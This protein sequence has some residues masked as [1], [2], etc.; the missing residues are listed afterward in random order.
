MSKKL[1]TTLCVLLAIGL[2]GLFYLAYTESNFYKAIQIKSLIKEH[3]EAG[4]HGQAALLAKELLINHPMQKKD[5]TV[6]L[7]KMAQEQQLQSIPAEE[8]ATVVGVLAEFQLS[9]IRF[10]KADLFTLSSQKAQEL[11][12]SSPQIAEDLL[13]A[14]VDIVPEDRYQEVHETRKILLE[15]ILAKSPGNVKYSVHLAEIYE[16]DGDANKCITILY[17]LAN[18]LGDTEGARILGRLL[19]AD[20]P[21]TAYTLLKGYVD[22]WLPRFQSADKEYTAIREN[23]WAKTIDDLNRGRG[24]DE[25][26]EAYNKA[27]EAKQFELIQNY[28]LKR[29]ENNSAYHAAYANYFK[30]SNVVSAAFDFGILLT[31]RAQQ[32][33]DQGKRKSLLTEAEQTFLAIQSASNESEEFNLALGQVY[34]WLGKYDEGKTLFNNF[35]ELRARDYQSLM[36]ISVRLRQVGLTNEAITLL[37]EAYEKASTDEERYSTAEYRT[38]F[39]RGHE[40]KR[41]WLNRSNPSNPRVIAEVQVLDGEVAALKGDYSKAIKHF[42]NAIAEYKKMEQDPVILNDTALIYSNLYDI[43]GDIEQLKTFGSLLTQAAQL[44][45]KDSIQL[46]NTASAL[47]QIG[48]TEIVSKFVDLSDIKIR[49]G[50][51]TLQFLY[52][53]HTE[54]IVFVDKLTKNTNLKKSETMFN[55]LLTLSPK[56]PYGYSALYSIYAANRNA[57]KLA[58]L[59]TKANHASIDHSE[60]IVLWKKSIAGEYDESIS[61]S[62]KSNLKRYKEII[63]RIDPKKEPLKYAL[64]ASEIVDSSIRLYTIDNSYKPENILKI[65]DIAHRHSP[66]VATRAM[67]RSVLVFDIYKTILASERTFAA[68]HKRFGKVAPQQTILAYAIDRQPAIKAKYL[69]HNNA[70]KL[71]ALISEEQAKTPDN[72]SPEKWALVRDSDTQLANNTLGLLRNNK[73]TAAYAKLDYA[74]RPYDFSS[75]MDRYWY[76]MVM[77]EPKAAEDL[78][79]EYAELEILDPFVNTL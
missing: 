56:S 54:Q 45:P 73:F 65:A 59:Y 38:K 40:D 78:L 52:D 2:S 11:S 35:L 20:E 6:I 62:S 17:P 24:S 23:T 50:Y 36:L 15:N 75:T 79:K 43:T 9:N 34:F 21:D 25:F 44:N 28:Y 60:S 53:S 7:K 33:D 30:T 12:D 4:R 55:T 58:D 18:Q 31:D 13:Y 1:L 37:E 77:D 16:I 68:Y 8:L 51:G 61:D 48:I 10:S 57:E 49:A 41:L 67:L 19:Y 14:V 27:N 47:R 22:I 64:V 42:N 70:G 63:S 74:I 5:A 32:A 71:V 29:L 39:S 72:L 69:A 66:S 3:Q 26:Y 76:S 46:H